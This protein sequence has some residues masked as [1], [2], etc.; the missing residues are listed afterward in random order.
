MTRDSTSRTDIVHGVWAVIAESGLDGVSMRSVAR[1]AGVSV[2]R[3][4]HH[5]GSRA[6]LVRESARAMIG[7]AAASYAPPETGTGAVDASTAR[8]LVTH[9]V[10]VAP[11]QRRGTT[12]WL[13]YLAA[14]VADPVLAEILGEAKRGQEGAVTRLLVA[15]TG[16][17]EAI[18]RV[19]A[20]RLIALA[21]GLASRVLVGDLTAADALAVIDDAWAD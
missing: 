10:P 2:G 13:S 21:D 12:I 15:D 7:G 1:A 17:P 6:D 18:C 4:Q 8:L 5:F 3:I 20:R 19:R 11:D 9:V 14:S 16:E